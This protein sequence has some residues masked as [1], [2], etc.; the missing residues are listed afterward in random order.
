VAPVDAELAPE[1]SAERVQLTETVKP[2]E[3]ITGPERAP[4]E[5]H[6]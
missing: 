3:P 2:D 6:Q 4:G 1:R 5:S